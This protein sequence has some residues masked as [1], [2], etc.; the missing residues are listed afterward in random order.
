[1]YRYMAYNNKPNNWSFVSCR[2]IKPCITAC[3]LKV[4]QWCFL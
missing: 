1:M 2:V 4:T 3:I